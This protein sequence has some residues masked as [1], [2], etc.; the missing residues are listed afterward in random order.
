MCCRLILLDAGCFI[1]FARSFCVLLLEVLEV[2]WAPFGKRVSGWDIFLPHNSVIAQ[3]LCH[4]T[5]SV[6]AFSLSL[7]ISS[8]H[9]D[10]PGT[11]VLLTRC[12]GEKGHLQLICSDPSHYLG[13]RQMQLLCTALPKNRCWRTAQ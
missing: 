6:S 2:D 13:S 8:L 4:F 7:R 9:I 5:T 3:R 1:N 12:A 11:E 10:C